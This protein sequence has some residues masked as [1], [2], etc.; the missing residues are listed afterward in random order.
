MILC[1]LLRTSDNCFFTV[2]VRYRVLDTVKARYCLLHAGRGR[3]CLLRTIEKVTF[4]YR[5]IPYRKTYRFPIPETTRKSVAAASP[6]IFFI[7]LNI[8]CTN[9]A[10]APVKLKH[11]FW[12]VEK[13]TI[14]LPTTLMRHMSVWNPVLQ[15]FPRSPKRACCTRATY[16][17][18]SWYTE[19]WSTDASVFKG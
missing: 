19:S 3:E 1:S 6:G 15:G 7:L 14:T 4:F 13:I 2:E 17:H 11:L 10:S 12:S 9:A 18:A 5:T 8:R 16:W